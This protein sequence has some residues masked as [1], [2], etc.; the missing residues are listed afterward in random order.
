MPAKFPTTGRKGWE[1]IAT[2]ELKAAAELRGG[3]VGMARLI[4]C[5]GYATAR[6]FAA[7]ANLHL[8]D[9]TWFAPPRL[10]GFVF[11]DIKPLEFHPCA[12]QTLFFRV[13]GFPPSS[14]KI[15]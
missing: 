13:E 12:G 14:Q 2:P 10:Y 4:A 11:R 6:G 3:I 9:P 7:D 5:K 8:N 1:R 15:S